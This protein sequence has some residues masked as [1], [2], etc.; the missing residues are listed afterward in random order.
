MSLEPDQQTLI[1]IKVSNLQSRKA[2]FALKASVG[3]LGRMRAFMSS[4]MLGTGE[5]LVADV[6]F[7][8][9]YLDIFTIA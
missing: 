2:L 9:L 1:R 7:Y 6:T 3:L 5:D 8:L 4:E